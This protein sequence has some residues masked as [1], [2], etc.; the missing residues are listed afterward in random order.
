MKKIFKKMASLKTTKIIFLLAN[1]I[2]VID[3][4]SI[5]TLSSMY[6]MENNDDGLVISSIPEYLDFLA[7][8]LAIFF[9][10]LFYIILAFFIDFISLIT[11]IIFRKDLFKNNISNIAFIAIV[12]ILVMVMTLYVNVIGNFEEINYYVLYML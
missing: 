12:G 9:P 10:G 8:V 2:L 11:L 7:T 3:L 4:L 6:P 5:K 1:L